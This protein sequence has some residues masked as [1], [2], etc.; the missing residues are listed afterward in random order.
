MVQPSRKDELDL[1]KRQ[2]NLSEYTAAY[3]YMLDRQASNRNSVAMRGP[4]RDKI[5]ITRNANGTSHWMYFSVTD[6]RDHG[7]IIDF[8]DRRERLSPGGIRQALH[9]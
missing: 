9:P 5:I 8:L 6:E 2:I 7:P 4:G 3:G 1:F